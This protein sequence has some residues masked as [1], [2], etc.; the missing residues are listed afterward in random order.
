MLSKTKSNIIDV[1]ISRALIGSY[2]SNEEFT[3]IDNVLKKY[4]D[5]K[6]KVKNLKS[7]TV[8]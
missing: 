2:I 6:E 8:Y 4:N 5:M 1:L 3:S 7:S